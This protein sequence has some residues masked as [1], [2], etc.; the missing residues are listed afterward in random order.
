MV[1]VEEKYFQR[2]YKTAGM[3]LNVNAMIYSKFNYN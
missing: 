3:L 2:N 1:K